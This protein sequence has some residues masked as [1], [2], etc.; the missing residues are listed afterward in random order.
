[1]QTATPAVLESASVQKCPTL[2]QLNIELKIALRQANR[3]LR[4]LL[5]PP[6]DQ[7]LSDWAESNLVLR[8]GTSSRPGPWRTESYQKAILDALRDPE[9]REAIF[10]KAT[11]VG[12]S[13][14]LNAIAGYFIDADPSPILFVQGSTKTAEEYS[15]KRMAPLIADCPAL[16]KKI[17]PANSRRAGNTLLLKEFDGGF[18]RFASAGAA[19]TLR[20]D[21][22]RILIFDEVDG[23]DLD[24][25]GEG[26]PIDIATRRTDSYE[27]A[28][29]LKGSTPA[30]PKGISQIDNDFL[31][32]DQNY[33]WVPCPFCEFMQPLVWRDLGEFLRPDEVAVY[34]G[35]FGT[36]AYRLR[37]EKDE[38]G[39]PIPGTVR[40][41]C[42]KCDRGIDEKYKQQMLDAGEWR[43]RFP[44]RRD[45][46]GYKVVGFHLNALYSPWKS[47]VWSA[48]AQEWWEATDNPE[49]LKAFV[50]LRLGETWDEGAGGSL[51]EHALTAR[52]EKYPPAPT[53]AKDEYWQ[54][55]LV[56]ERCCLLVGTADIQSAG[57]G[58]IEAQITG[59]GPGEESYLVAYEVFWGDAGAI[60]DPETGIS[61]WAELDKFFLREWRHESGALLRPAI[62]LVDSGDQTDAVYEYV[63]PRQIPKRRVYACKGVEYLSRPGMAAEGTAKR[64]HIR[65]WNIATVSAKDRIFSRLRIP[66][67]PDGKPKPGYHH[68]P[69]WVTEEYLRQLTSEQKI[70]QRDK[71]TRRLRQRY[72]SVHGRNEA[73][74]LTVYAHGA[75]FILQNFIDPVTFRNMDRLHQLVMNASS[76]GEKVPVSMEPRPR[77]GHRILSEGIKI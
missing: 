52:L 19:K 37:W 61:V 7:S 35:I 56:P 71:R 57:G 26:N 22:I 23:Y 47:T 13:A 49:K 62:C 65:L 60:I 17:Q 39:A 1:M 12:W 4:E 42:A 66:P 15:K 75:L 32:S 63:L 72:V 24:C 3:E 48:L 28:K 38:K 76:Q 58:R 44:G 53:K 21:Q 70:T 29:I 36:G 5:A 55:Y 69:D 77:T 33:Y 41:Y 54:N 16:S 34:K 20:S 2:C 68:L 27:D 31:R 51:D 50:N 25:E 6:P 11:Q 10:R 40:Y 9:V 18:L 74:D 64:H 43:P 30:K 14:I 8:K 59:F 67:A 45:T 46:E 73:L